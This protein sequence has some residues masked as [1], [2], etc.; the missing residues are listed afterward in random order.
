MK[1]TEAFFS[2]EV[3][4]MDRA[5]AFYVAAFDAE[6]TFASPR[7]SSLRIAGVR[8]GLF[9]HPA[10]E[11]K[12]IGL[13]F[14]VDD[15]EAA[16]AAIASA[17]GTVLHAAVEVAPGVVTADVADTEGNGFTLTVAS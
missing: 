17:G 11:T 4:D 9:H 2:I 15:L 6:V 7:W 3:G 10:L 12:K 16:C 8:L 14:A 1:V 13:H 5:S